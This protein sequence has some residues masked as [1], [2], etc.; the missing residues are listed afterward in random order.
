MKMDSMSAALMNEDFLPD[1][2]Y[3]VFRK[4]TPRWNL[5]EHFVSD[6]DIT[7]L[8]KGNARYTVNGVPHRVSAGDVVC[9]SEGD[10]KAAATNPDSPMECLSVNCKLRRSDGAELRLPFPSVSHI[11]Q[12]QDVVHLFH[13]LIYVWFDRQPGYIIKARGL[14]LLIIH[15]FFEL[16]GVHDESAVRDYRVNKIARYIIAHYAERILVRD[17]ARMAG[18]NAVYLGALFKQE[19][20]KTLNQYVIQARVRNAE[21]M[22]RSGEHTVA[23]TAALCGYADVFHFYKQ[24]KAITGNAPSRCLPKQ[25]NHLACPP[26]PRGADTLA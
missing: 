5:K 14:M 23:E 9:F 26:P 25:A 18:L 22:L 3:L 10:L 2:Q 17:M 15:R 7:Y 24:F 8:I 6:C 19:T 16:T 11:G 20:G 1:I 12:Q 13:E 21:A 4:T